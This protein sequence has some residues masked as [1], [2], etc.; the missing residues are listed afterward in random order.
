[1]T[2]SCVTDDR[3]SWG[4][5]ALWRCVRGF[6]VCQYVG[7]PSHALATASLSCRSPGAGKVYI[8]IHIYMNIYICIHVFTCFRDS[9]SLL[10]IARRWQSLYICTY[11]HTHVH[12][13]I[14]I[15]TCFRNIL[16][17]PSIARRWQGLYIYTHMYT[18]ICMRIHIYMYI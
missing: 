1:M 8:C 4:V 2:H 12:I 6:P 7:T 16:P 18:Y 17:L 5:D 10:S 9:L 13:Y 14:Y 15:Y 3:I 11:I